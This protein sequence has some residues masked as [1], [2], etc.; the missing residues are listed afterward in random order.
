M[1]PEQV[2]SSIL[3]AF[4]LTKYAARSRR[5][6]GAAGFSYSS[7][8]EP[9]MP[10]INVSVWKVTC[11]E[12]ESAHGPDHL[13][14]AGAVIV[15]G[16]P[17]SFIQPAWAITRNQSLTYI[18]PQF[19]GYSES[20]RVGLVLRAW[21]ID[22]ND[23]WVKHRDTIG[24]VTGALAEA[25][26]HL[27]VV[28]DVAGFI[29]EHWP[30][31]VDFFADLDEND[32]LLKWAGYMPIPSA[33]PNRTRSEEFELRFSRR[34]PAGLHSWDYSL[35]VAITAS[36]PQPLVLA[37]PPRRSLAPK[38]AT[39]KPH[40]YGRWESSHFVVSISDSPDSISL[41]SVR[42]ESRNGLF[43][44]IQEYP[45]IA[46]PERI[47][48]LYEPPAIAPMER[49]T[50]LILAAGHTA[51]LTIPEEKVGW[52]VALPEPGKARTSGGDVLYLSDG[53]A[54]EMFEVLHDGEPANQTEIRYLRPPS[55]L[56]GPLPVEEMFQKVVV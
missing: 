2:D 41:L 29:L 15:D 27:P 22:N 11:R 32:E 6:R 49:Q 14:V 48:T 40:W 21:D 4:T 23:Q 35:F 44:T 55:L 13:G 42:I 19:S 24:E 9:K 43:P 7:H 56:F 12:R 53:G 3:L 5:R 38:S 37:P 36:N 28:G 33:A 50:A 54:L 45:Y 17:H 51:P 25:V 20:M 47:N 34:D 16:Q 46:A 30:A 10:F 26:G 39:R 52:T 1:R 8:A 31:A 18:G